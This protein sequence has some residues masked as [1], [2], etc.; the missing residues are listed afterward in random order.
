MKAKIYTQI[1]ENIIV[2]PRRSVLQYR[3]NRSP[4]HLRNTINKAW[5][6]VGIAFMRNDDGDYYAVEEFSTEEII[7]T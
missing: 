4:L 7:L 2:D 5:T 6:R 3:L 1:G